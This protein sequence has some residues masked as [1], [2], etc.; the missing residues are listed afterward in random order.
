MAIGKVA[1]AVAGAAAI[2]ASVGA[3]PALSAEATLR[4]ASCFPIGSP[5]SKPFEAYVKEVNK[6][7]KGL[8]QIK[9]IG[10]A[11]AIG[12]PFTLT[13]KMAKG[14]FDI[15]GC[16][17][18]YFGN[19][20]PEGAAL[21]LSQKSYA[22]LRRN[23]GIAYMQKLFATKNIHYVAR[24][25][26]FG[27][28]YLFLSKKIAKANLKGLHLR[29]S[30]IYIAFFTSLGATVQR[31][32]Y[33]QIYT[34]MENGTV[35]GYGWPALGWN[36]SWIKVTKYRVEPG[37]YDAV[38]HTVANLK[39]WKSLT[40]AQQAVLTKVGM[41]FE[42]ASETSSP[43]FKAL[44]AKQK[45]KTAKQGMAA[46]ELTGAEKKKWLSAAYEEAWAEILKRSPKHGA[47][48]KALFLNK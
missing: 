24:H 2:L 29:V 31:S 14:A 43:E 38:L 25:H 20:L 47:K 12:S 46:I 1:Y 16:T 33:A 9:M 26:S 42:R 48:L 11:P 21:R 39:K 5:T 7:G 45:A 37:F 3:A 41:R 8:V 19:V 34:Y 15:I 30:P 23:G 4:G 32:N 35:R 27:P 22:E 28:F 13:K 18:G 17:E 40:K 10:G 36:P 6:A 44:L